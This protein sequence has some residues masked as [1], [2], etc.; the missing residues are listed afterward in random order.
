MQ[1][2]LAPSNKTERKRD[3]MVKYAEGI[4]NQRMDYSFALISEHLPNKVP[5]DIIASLASTNVP[6]L[7]R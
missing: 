4:E 5:L 6:I 2:L 3:P 7:H 1:D